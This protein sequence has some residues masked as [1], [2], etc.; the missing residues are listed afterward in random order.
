MGEVSL[1][2]WFAFLWA[3]F[4]LS[5]SSLLLGFLCLFQVEARPGLLTPFTYLLPMETSTG[6]MEQ[7]RVTLWSYSL[8]FQ[9]HQWLYC[10]TPSSVVPPSIKWRR[11]KAK[12]KTGEWMLREHLLG[13]RRHTHCDS[14]L[15]WLSQWPWWTWLESLLSEGG[16]RSNSPTVMQVRD[17]V[18]IPWVANYF[19]PSGLW[20]CYCW[21]SACLWSGF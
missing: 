13:F 7:P 12:N 6:V 16:Q 5:T 9:Q 15:F 2:F 14:H 4:P 3:L 8:L 21:R 10:L 1:R 20:V 19:L 17:H 11:G 18:C